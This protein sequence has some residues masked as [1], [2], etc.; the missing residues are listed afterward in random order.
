MNIKRMIYK[1]LQVEYREWNVF[2]FTGWTVDI[3]KTYLNFYYTHRARYFWP[4][5]QICKY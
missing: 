3:L 2:V 4:R 1:R 5:G